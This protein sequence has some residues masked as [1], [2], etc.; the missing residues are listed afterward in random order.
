MTPNLPALVDP[1]ALDLPAAPDVVL[2]HVAD[3]RAYVAAHLPGA[4]LVEPREL[5]HGEPPAAGRLPDPARLEALFGALGH[6]PELHYLV[7]DDE[8]GGWAGRFVWTL[9]VIGHRRWSYLD[10]G[11]HAWH[12]LG[13]PLEAGPPPARPGSAQP[14]RLTLEPGPRAQLADVRAAIGD[15]EQLIWDARSPEEYRGEKSGARRAGHIPGA[16]NLDWLRLMDPARERRLVADLP[17]LLARHGIDPDK[18]I[19]THCQTH[20]RS[21]LSYLVGRLLGFRDIRGYDGSWGEWGNRD[22]TPI[23]TG[24]EPDGAAASR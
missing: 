19:I 20:H 22:D 12:G 4:V 2:V 8:G 13:R 1:G 5:I 10:G 21:G 16:R 23:V 6:R 7:Y 9:E 18:R 15:P 3:A 11:L 24:S 17:E 14:L